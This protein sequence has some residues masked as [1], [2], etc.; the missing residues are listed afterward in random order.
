M[1]TEYGPQTH[2]CPPLTAELLFKYYNID[3]VIDDTEKLRIGK[4]KFEARI[5]PIGVRGLLPGSSREEGGT[6]Q[7]GYSKSTYVSFFSQMFLSY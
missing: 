2:G 7:F 6:L 1:T 5:F 4:T 3:H